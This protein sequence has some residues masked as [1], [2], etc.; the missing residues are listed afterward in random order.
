MGV[1]ETVRCDQV[2][3][4]FLNQFL[5]HGSKKDETKNAAAKD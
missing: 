1:I 2:N 3:A 5:M 4:T